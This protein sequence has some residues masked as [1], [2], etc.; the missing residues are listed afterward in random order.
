[1]TGPWNGV[2]FPSDPVN[3]NFADFPTLG[4]DANGVYLSADMFDSSWV[5][6]GPTLL[7]LPKSDLLAIPPSI[8]G[9]TWFGQMSYNN[10]GAILQPS[11]SLSSVSNAE[12]VLAVGD[13]GYDG[14][15]HS[16]LLACRIQ[17][18]TVS[19]GATVTTA[20]DLTVPDYFIPSYPVQ[21]S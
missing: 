5:S 19:G 21:P 8:G 9:L 3:G 20:L 17:N 13:L 16:S 10:Y 4:I 15:P 7:S 2:A 6:I 1:P 11:I 18:A 12:A 14:M